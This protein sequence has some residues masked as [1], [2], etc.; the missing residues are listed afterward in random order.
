[1]VH[2]V[3]MYKKRFSPEK[4]EK[5]LEAVKNEEDS[6][7]LAEF[8]LHND[9][10]NI[11]LEATNRIDDESILA[12]IAQNDSNKKVRIAAIGKISDEFVL[13]DIASNDSNKSVRQVAD[14][15][16]KELGHLWNFQSLF[17]HWKQIVNY[18]IEKIQ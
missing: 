10:S 8:A 1:M 14:D 3:D 11:R 12:D 5:D 15:R 16:L 6:K 7:K 9:F 13:A 2:V 4:Y 18:E 17:N